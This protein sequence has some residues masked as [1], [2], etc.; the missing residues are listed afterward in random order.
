MGFLTC[1]AH[2]VAWATAHTGEEADHHL[3]QALDRVERRARVEPEI[4]ALAEA[5]RA[6]PGLAG[7]EERAL[8]LLAALAPRRATSGE[9]T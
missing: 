3:Q 1:L 5:V 6:H 4:R 9:V 2:V 8:R 7:Q